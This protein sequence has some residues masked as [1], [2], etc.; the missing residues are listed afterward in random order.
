MYIQKLTQ[1]PKLDSDVRIEENRPSKGTEK[2]PNTSSILDWTT[3]T[4]QS[5]TSLSSFNS[6]L[7]H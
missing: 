3:P 2:Q 4:T 7:T 5:F 6:K 1:F